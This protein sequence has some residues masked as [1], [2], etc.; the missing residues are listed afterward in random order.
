MRCASDQ[1]QIIDELAVGVGNL[2]HLGKN[3]GEEAD[4]HVVRRGAVAS[5]PLLWALGGLVTS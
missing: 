4:L 2:K 3:I 1:D 5:R